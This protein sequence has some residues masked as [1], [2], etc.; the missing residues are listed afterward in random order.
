MPFK[1]GQSGNP[2]GKPKGALN[3]T[4][5]IAQNML[6]GQA[7]ALVEKMIQL[8]LHGDL[9]CL[10]VCI[11]RLVPPKREEPIDIDLPEIGVTADIPKLFSALTAKLRE[12]RTTPT[13]AR[14]LI[15]LA[16]AARR[17]F[18][19]AEFEKRIS[20]LEEEVKSRSLQDGQIV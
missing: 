18:E 8:A 14:A 11:E 7:E 13:E 19:A 9:T 12:G 5:L 2:N 4:T 16:E 1:K 20:A 10:R 15:D 3:R 17:L 6:E